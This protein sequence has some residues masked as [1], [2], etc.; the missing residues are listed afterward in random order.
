M[1]NLY[2]AIMY[3]SMESVAEASSLRI[4]IDALV[5]VSLGCKSTSVWYLP[6]TILPIIGFAY[7][8]PE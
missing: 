7:L 5:A 2:L 3:G 6:C 4:D 1:E 8:R